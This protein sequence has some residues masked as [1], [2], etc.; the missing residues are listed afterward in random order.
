[1]RRIVATLLISGLLASSAP[2][3]ARRGDDPWNPIQ[4]IKKIVRL[5][6]PIPADD[7][8]NINPPKP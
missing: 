1:M 2:T 5:L 8:N 3:L 4:L 6:I 7:S